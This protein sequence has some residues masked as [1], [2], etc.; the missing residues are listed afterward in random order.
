M[1]SITLTSEMHNCKSQYHQSVNNVDEGLEALME[2]QMN[3]AG[4][5]NLN[6]DGDPIFIDAE[7]KPIGL[8]R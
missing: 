6:K 1:P 5:S 3:G 8:R 2:R 4:W 7:V